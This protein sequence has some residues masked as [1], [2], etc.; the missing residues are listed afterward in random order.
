MKKQSGKQ[1]VGRKI[2][3]DFRV[4]I[5]DGGSTLIN[6]YSEMFKCL[7]LLFILLSTS[8]VADEG[9]WYLGLGLGKAKPQLELDEHVG[10]VDISL[11]EEFGGSQH[12]IPVSTDSEFATI[13]QKLFL[14]YDVGDDKGFAFELSLTNFGLYEGTMKA[15]VDNFSSIP[16]SHSLDGIQT[17]KADLYATTISLIYSFKL[18]DKVSIFPRL[19]MSHIRGTVHTQTDITLT[20]S[21]LGESDT[22][23]WSD[24]DNES[25]SVVL[26]M[27]GIGMDIELVNQ[28]FIRA[29]FERYGHP[30]K[31]YVDMYNVS[32]GYNFN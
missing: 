16:Y 26:P 18:G 6:E 10:G 31:E 19:G 30:T 11:P 2:I 23:N 12:S 14:G 22:R 9:K 1:D 8:A 29:E 32:W 28:Y 7:P 20:T 15:S 17:I 24:T 25:L 3:V 4:S 5:K 13:G 21:F 27:F